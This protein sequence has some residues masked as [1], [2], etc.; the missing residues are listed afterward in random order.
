VSDVRTVLELYEGGEGR[1]SVDLAF[2]SWLLER[3]AAGFCC[4]AVYSWPG[5]VVVLGYAQDPGEVDLDWCGRAGI[6]VLRRLTGG[7]GVIHRRDLALSLALPAR[8]P[9]ARGV[10]GLY[11]RLLDAVAPALRSLGSAVGRVDHPQRSGRA[12]SPVC[13]F[14]R[15]ADT[16]AV[17][18]RKAVGCAQTRRRGAVL[19]HAAILLGLEPAL[20]ARA[21]GVDEGRVGRE[22]APALD[23]GEWRSTGR[24]VVAG[25]AAALEL[26]AVRLPSPDPI[27]EHLA[28]YEL[29]RWAP[30]PER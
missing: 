24:V 29:P 9:W 18:G 19:V 28:R 1:P 14:D 11:H 7:T 8:H 16:L 21:F 30:V 20:Y 3:A 2:E 23:G 6:P 22:L 10:I 27:R 25:I 4:A 17:D 15:H 12:R 5:P 13:F 26:D